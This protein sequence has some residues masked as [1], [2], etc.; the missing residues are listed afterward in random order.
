MEWSGQMTST[1]MMS[2][3]VES[4]QSVYSSLI[5]C[6]PRTRLWWGHRLSSLVI[7]I[8]IDKPKKNKRLCIRLSQKKMRTKMDL[9]MHIFS[10]SR[11]ELTK[12]IKKYWRLKNFKI[13]RD[14][15]RKCTRIIKLSW[16]EVF[17]GWA[18]FR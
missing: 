15:R 13:M 16:K 7:F 6:L 12:F 5:P 11:N 4:I 14:N 9:N 8:E 2:N 3:K 18:F 17:S 1:S 10:P